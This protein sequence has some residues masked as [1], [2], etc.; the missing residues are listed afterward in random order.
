[1]IGKYAAKLDEKRKND[2]A[3]VLAKDA[4]VMD[5]L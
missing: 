5:K 1:M 2:A 4:T 3:A